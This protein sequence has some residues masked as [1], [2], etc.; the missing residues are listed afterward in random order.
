MDGKGGIMMCKLKGGCKREHF[1]VQIK[2]A[3]G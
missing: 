3:D 2:R 1:D